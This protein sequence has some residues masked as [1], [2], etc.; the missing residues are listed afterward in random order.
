MAQNLYV[1]THKATNASWR[2]GW[3]RTFGK[4]SEPCSIGDHVKLARKRI[5][6]CPRCGKRTN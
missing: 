1:G 2:D 5:Y 4:K 3:E 6:K